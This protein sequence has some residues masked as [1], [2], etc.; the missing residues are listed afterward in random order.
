MPELFFRMWPA[1]ILD[2]MKVRAVGQSSEA[3]EPPAS[4]NLIMGG[5]HHETNHQ[6]VPRRQSAGTHL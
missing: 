3:S 6:N 5:Q 1:A 4:Q 2:T